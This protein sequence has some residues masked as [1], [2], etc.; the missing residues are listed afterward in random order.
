[1][2]RILLIG[3]AALLV[4]IAVGGV[5][6]WRTLGESDPVLAA[7]ALA[8]YRESPTP[9]PPAPGLPAPGV[10]EY[11]V[12]GT[13][14]LSRGPLDVERD[15]PDLAPMIVRHRDDGY[16]TDLRYS[17]QHTELSRYE[18]RGDGSFVTFA[19]TVVGAAGINT[20][21]D[22]EW[23]PPLLRLPLGT[24]V[25][26]EWGG[27]Y[28]AGDLELRIENEILRMEMVDVGGTPVE[29][30]VIESRQDVTGG[31]TGRRVETFWYS[32][33]RGL[34][35]RYTIESS[36]DGDTDFDI[37]ADQTLESLTPQT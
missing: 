8:E 32:P 35:V 6:F 13:E 23:T 20:T 37:A 15:L 19:R 24:E 22:R 30:A 11:R 10:Y 26:R 14:R 36:L 16:E 7:D 1:M 28:A 25:G 21:R 4:V 3:T 9:G 31:F 27:P 29:A 17:E 12:T 18:F 2:T 34:V 33:P 5:L